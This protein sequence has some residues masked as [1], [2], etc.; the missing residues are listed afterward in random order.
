MRYLLTI[1]IFYSFNVYSQD[2]TTH[3]KAPMY[4]R[5]S[6]GFVYTSTSSNQSNNA[7]ISTIEIGKTFNAFDLGICYGSDRSFDSTQFV[8]L[9][10]TM[11]ATQY[12]RFSCEMILGVGRTNNVNTPMMFEYTCSMMSQ[13]NDKISFGVYIG[14]IDYRGD[15]INNSNNIFGLSIRYGALR[16]SNGFLMRSHRRS[17]TKHK[18]R[19]R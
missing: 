12:D 11:L 3:H 5:M 19:V 14:Y 17:I 18:V 16:D 7:V 10:G 6:P 1:I 8:E 2:S 13:L 4:Y 15:V 9:K